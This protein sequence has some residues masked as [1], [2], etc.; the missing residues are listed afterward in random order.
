MRGVVLR[1][2]FTPEDLVRVRVAPGPH[3]TWELTLSINSLQSPKLPVEHWEWRDALTRTTREDLDSRRWLGAA[4]ALVPPDGN[5]PDFLTPAVVDSDLE[6]HFETIRALPKDLVREDLRRT[7]HATKPP[8]W[9]RTLYHDGR[10]NGVVDVLRRYH[11]LALSR[12]WRSVHQHVEADRARYAK[13]LLAG[14]VEAL[15]NGLHPSIRFQHPVLEADYPVDRTINLAGRG[16]V[17][18]PAHFCWEKPITFMDTANALQPMLVCPATVD[19]PTAPTEPDTTAERV[20]R[21]AAMLGP[22]RARLLAELTIADTTTGLATRLAVTPAAVSQHTAILR[23]AGLLTTARVGR[24]VRHALT[25]L[26]R[27]LLNG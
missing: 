6:A 17:V 1:I 23:Q 22:T 8:R 12:D 2:H 3:P 25:P 5:Y 21:L 10:T 15:L 13:L 16:L 19:T 26:G 14:G 9:A 7:F 4:A 24:A 27:A 11:E 20:N 18:V